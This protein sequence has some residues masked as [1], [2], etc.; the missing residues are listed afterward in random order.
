ML[1]SSKKLLLDSQQEQNLY[2]TNRKKLSFLPNLVV[3]FFIFLIISSLIWIFKPISE[4]TV[5]VLAMQDLIRQEVKTELN[6]NLTIQLTS[7]NNLVDYQEEFL[8]SLKNTEFLTKAFDLQR[9]QDKTYYLTNGCQELSLK[10]N[11]CQLWSLDNFTNQIKLV[12]DLKNLSTQENIDFG[13]L[14]FA[15]TQNYQEGLNLIIVYARSRQIRLLRLNKNYELIEVKIL[16]PEDK[17]FS[18]YQK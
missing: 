13:S 5:P 7:S 15:K 3:T 4:E 12:K 6:Q 11:I 1:F 9:F 17:E 10:E 18:I 16:R 14:K 2:Q 8:E